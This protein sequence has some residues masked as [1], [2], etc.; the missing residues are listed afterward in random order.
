MTYNQEVR[1]DTQFFF[2]LETLV[3]QAHT[4]SLKAQRKIEP[5]LRQFSFKKHLPDPLSKQAIVVHKTLSYRFKKGYLLRPTDL[6]R[7]LAWL[8]EA[9]S[10]LFE[11]HVFSNETDFSALDR[12]YRRI[13]SGLASSDE[14]HLQRFQGHFV[15]ESELGVKGLRELSELGV[16]SITFAHNTADWMSDYTYDI[17]ELQVSLDSSL[18]LDALQLRLPDWRWQ[19]DVTSEYLDQNVTLTKVSSWVDW[20][21]ILASE[22]ESW[23]ENR[24]IAYL[25]DSLKKMIQE[26]YRVPIDDLFQ[27]ERE[28]G[29][30][31][32]G[33]V[34]DSFAVTTLSLYAGCMYLLDQNAT[35]KHV[36]QLA[37]SAMPVYLVQ[38]GGVEWVIPAYRLI[39]SSSQMDKPNH[40][41]RYS[42]QVWQ[43]VDTQPEHSLYA[44]E[45]STGQ[46]VW[47]EAEN[48]QRHY[49]VVLQ[50]TLLPKNLQNVWRIRDRFV[51]EPKLHVLQL[52]TS[53]MLAK[54]N[55]VSR[56]LAKTF[57]PVLFELGAKNGLELYADQVFGVLPVKNI[58]LASPGFVYY[59]GQLI[60]YLQPHSEL[61]T[62]ED[63]VIFVQTRLLSMAF[64]GRYSRTSQTVAH[65]LLEGA[66][67]QVDWTNQCINVSF[68][69]P[70][71]VLLDQSH[72]YLLR[73]KLLSILE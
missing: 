58:E 19:E 17:V 10:I 3:L 70:G 41:W 5:L 11:L 6:S 29:L 25:Y 35:A 48:V 22:R 67:M 59:C 68:S 49:G 73:Q 1:S 18:A 66:V 60:P 23:R 47:M 54:S 63:V 8:I 13:L 42:E 34:P 64:R 50:A 69:D 36:Y 43:E 2:T 55:L 16:W 28:T 39:L 30:G 20:L 72:V 44:V 26:Q 52:S 53:I 12:L 21:H 51:A 71:W 14:P 32:V 46:L 24:A 37:E 7:L 33:H 65:T 9:R 45:T 4:Q 61:C 27:N 62:D 31:I 57:D 40:F 56:H 38:A 15:G